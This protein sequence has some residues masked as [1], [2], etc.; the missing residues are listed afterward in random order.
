MLKC[1]YT[2]C[3]IYYTVIS[4]IFFRKG[5]TSLVDTVVNEKC[6]I[7]DQYRNGA[8]NFEM[9]LHAMC[10]QTCLPDNPVKHTISY[11]RIKERSSYL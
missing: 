7:Q 3:V 11:M 8:V 4:S 10:A 1:C 2:D 9:R 5:T 6:Y